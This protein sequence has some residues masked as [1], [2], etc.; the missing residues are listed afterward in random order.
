MF[1]ITVIVN[2]ITVNIRVQILLSDT[3][4]IS[5]LYPEVGLLDHKVVLFLT[6]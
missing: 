4:F 2:N 1:H 6:F 3:I 5:F